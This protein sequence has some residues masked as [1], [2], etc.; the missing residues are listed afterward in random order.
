MSGFGAASLAAQRETGASAPRVLIIEDDP[1]L[2]QVL[3]MAAERRGFHVTTALD[4]EEGLN[5]AQHTTPDI[6]ILDLMLPVVDGFTV[7]STLRTASRTAHTPIIVVS[8]RTADAE[9]AHGLALGAND[10]LFKPFNVREV[11]A[12]AESLVTRSR[13][14]A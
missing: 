3:R 4:G 9:R 11:M 5:T 2:S 12:R 1:G 14:A 8:A 6:I 13:A 10:Y 7:L